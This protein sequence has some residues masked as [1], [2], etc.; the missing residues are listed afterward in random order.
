MKEGLSMNRSDLSRNAYQLRG[1]LAK[2][3]YDWWWHNFT[4]YHHETGEAKSFFIEYFIIN[5]ALNEAKPVLGQ[6]PTHQLA[7][8]KPSYIM[9]K[10]GC[11]GK[12]AVQLHQFYP[13]SELKVKNIPFHLQVGDCILSETRLR[14]H[15]AL[16]SEKAAAH[17]EYMSDAGEMSWDLLL[18]KQITFNVGYGASKPLRDLNAFEMYWHAEGMKTEFAGTV[19]YNGELYNV[20][21]DKSYGYAD[22]NWGSNFTSPWLWLGC[23]HIVRKG[24]G[25]TLE[26]SVF[27][28]GG[29]CPKV[30]GIPLKRKLLM[31]FFYEGLDLE[32]NFSK[33][34][35]RSK[36]SY[37]VEETK[38]QVIWRLIA[39]DPNTF[40]KLRVACKKDEML[41]INYEAP[42]GTKRHNRLWNG[43]T[44]TGQLLLYKKAHG[45][46]IL[47][48]HLLL[49]NVGCEYG[50]YDH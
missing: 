23:S 32:Y 38:G 11:W 20:I 19:T 41:L 37:K 9:V 12:N 16:S 26:N 44:G 42:D 17:P 10:A 2:K 25:E 13:F 1:K 43:G 45:E 40:I 33:P 6:L 18:D 15:V 5:P 7:H 8:K 27:D 36:I 35:L 14:V 22:K 34:W 50:E 21:P 46:K 29:G 3:G 48:D 31:N 39:E 47:I 28:V 49:K 30:F 4:A 24:T